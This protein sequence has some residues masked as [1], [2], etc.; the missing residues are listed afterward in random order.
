MS[1][2]VEKSESSL[3]EPCD[4]FCVWDLIEPG[5]RVKNQR[6]EDC[7]GGVKGF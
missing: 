5:K 3:F 2:S 6:E 4:C 1:K 7:G